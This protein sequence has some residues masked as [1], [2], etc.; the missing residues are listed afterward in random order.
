MR[1][2][3]RIA[4]VVF[5]VIVL[6]LVSIPFSPAANAALYYDD[7]LPGP[8]DEPVSLLDI[9]DMTGSVMPLGAALKFPVIH[10]VESRK[11]GLSL[12]SCPITMDDLFYCL[13]YRGGPQ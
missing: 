12:L 13:S 7:W 2:I 8:L 4:S 5:L 1:H 10:W 9:C 3:M 11:Q 6:T